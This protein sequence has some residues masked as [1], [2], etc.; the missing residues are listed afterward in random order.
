MRK[1]EVAKGWEDKSINLPQRSTEFSAGYDFESAEDVTIPSIWKIWKKSAYKDGLNSKVTVVHTGIK[2]YMNDNEVL[3]VY[4]RSSNAIKRFLLMP[5]SIG[6]IDKDFVD[7]PSND[8]E[9]GVPLINFGFTDMHIKKG[10]RIAQ[11]VFK[12]Y[13]TVDDDG[14]KPKKTRV[15]GFGSTDT[16]D[17]TTA[18][19][20][21]LGG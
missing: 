11:G 6:V 15:G 1:F 13:L 4:P 8:G 2:V 18:G 7:N 10:E 5:N 14:L 21:N 17:V 12:Q 9:I 3:E 16:L 19:S 20:I